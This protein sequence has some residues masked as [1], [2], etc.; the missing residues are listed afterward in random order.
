[1]NYYVEL[2]QNINHLM[3][4]NQY[5]EALDLILDELKMPYVPKNTLE[6]LEQA[7]KEC[8]IELKIPAS[9][10]IDFEMIQTFLKDEDVML[11]QAA[12]IQ[13]K[14]INLRNYKS[15]IKELIE[16]ERD[17]LIQSMLVLECIEQELDLELQFTKF[18][19]EYEFN[20]L[21]V[22]HPINTDGYLEATEEIEELTFK[23]PSFTQLCQQ[24][25][26]KEVILA[27]PL[28]YEQE[29][30]KPLA[31][32]I[33]KLGLELL[34]RDDEWY[35]YTVQYKIEKERI[36]SLFSTL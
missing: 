31:Y 7:K 8:Q 28:S 9:K 16:S 14:E 3:N 35:D 2:E 34:K 15:E 11:K 18:K 25:L 13:L 23:E 32:S 1:M 33:I 6:F 5:Q 21:N 17:L 29:E 12:L 30:G 27:L 36:M 19:T 20:V 4:Q 24:L 26:V 10:G 22:Q